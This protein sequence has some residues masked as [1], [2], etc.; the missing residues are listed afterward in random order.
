MTQGSATKQGFSLVEMVIVILLIGLVASLAL[1][2]SIKTTPRQQVD[3]A[4]RQLVRDLELA[5][6]RAIAAKRRVRVMFDAPSRFYTAFMDLTPSRAAQFSESS[7]EARASR[8]V[9][10]GSQE[11]VPVIRLPN[12]VEFGVGAAGLSPLGES[13]TAPIELE[14]G[15]VEFDSRGMVVPL[16][17]GGTLY[18]THAEDPSAVAA[19]TISGTGAFRA[20]RYR[21]G[22]WE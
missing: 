20:W 15:R 3:R 21:N 7:E 19:V 22:E 16:G 6:M 17:G 14:E 8:L 5:R 12:D 18:L 13:V 2:R 4:T 1:P 10:R 11:G 9:F